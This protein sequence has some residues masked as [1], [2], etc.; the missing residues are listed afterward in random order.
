[1]SISTILNMG[2]G[3][4]VKLPVFDVPVPVLIVGVISKLNPNLA[5]YKMFKT[6]GNHMAKLF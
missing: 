3:E 6:I 1:M 4:K 5:L 2:P